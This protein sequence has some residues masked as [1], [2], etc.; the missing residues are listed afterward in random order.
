MD[1]QRNS[2]MSIQSEHSQRGC[3][4]RGS[5]SVKLHRCY[6]IDV[7][8]MRVPEPCTNPEINNRE[9]CGSQREICL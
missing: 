4:A 5:D 2:L 7:S 8:G 1:L 9:L 3:E 6:R